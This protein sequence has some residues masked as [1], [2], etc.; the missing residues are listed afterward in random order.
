[1]DKLQITAGTALDGE[2]RISG[3]KNAALLAA[4]MLATTDPELR[5]R[6]HAFREEQARASLESELP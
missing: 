4:G 6:L 5:S 2:V 3:A 1:L